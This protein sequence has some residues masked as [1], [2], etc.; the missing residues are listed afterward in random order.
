MKPF[1]PLTLRTQILLLICLVFVILTGL[2]T[3]KAFQ[4]FDKIKADKLN[5]FRL[6]ARW[7]VSEEQRHLMLARHVAFLVINQLR[8]GLTAK[9][10]R[11][12]VVGAPGLDRDFGKFALAATNGDVSCN[13]ISWLTS[14]NVAGQ[15][16]FQKALRGDNLDFIGE[17]DNRDPAKY[18]AIMAHTMR[19]QDGHA[20]KVILVGLDFSWIKEEIEKANLP[21]EVH[22]LMVD[23]KGVVI[24]GSSNMAS[25]VDRSIAD[26]VF[27]KQV[28]ASKETAFEGSGFAGSDS[29]ITVHSFST[30]SGDIRVIIDYPDDAI[31][32]SA[33]RDLATTIL[34][35]VVVLVLILVLAYYWSEKYFL[36][37]ISVIEDAA[38]KLA[39]GD[40]TAR[41]DLA[42]NDELAQLAKNFNMMA[43]AIQVHRAKDSFFA[44]MS[45]E[46][47]T[48]LTGMLGMMEVLSLTPLNREQNDTLRAAWSSGRSLLRIVSD[49]LDWSKIEEEGLALDPSS[50]SIF[51]LV[52]EVANTYSRVA[53][54]K[55]LS[56]FH[57]VDTRLSPA[58]IVD[59]MRL[60]QV[61][62][63][64]VS[65]A[66]KFTPRGEVELRADLLEK[67]ENSE[68]IC[69]SVRDTGIGIAKDVQQH[70][71]Q[72]YRQGSDDTTRLYGGTG[73]GLAICR[74][75]VESM[76]GLIELVSEPERGS[77]FSIIL[78]LPTSAVPL[79]RAPNPHPEVEE[80]AVK[81]LLDGSAEAPLVL[82]VDDHPINRNLLA[83]Q[84]KLL[85]LRAETAE[86][87]QMALSM[88]QKGHY[89]L[90]IT[91]CHM[92]EMDGYSLSRAIRNIE[93]RE[94]LPRTT[95]IAW[96]ANA[97]PEEAGYCYAA[98]M[99]ELLI[100]PTSMMQLKRVL[101]KWLFSPQAGGSQYELPLHDMDNEQNA[102]PIDYAELEKVVPDRAEHTQTL[103]DFE[104]HIRADREKLLEMLAQG[105]TVNVERTAHRMGGSC[106]MVG[107][108][109]LA[110]VCAAIERAGQNGD[111]AGARAEMT[112]LDK[113]LKQLEA[114]LSGMSKR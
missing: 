30:G 72:R 95:I 11:Q 69:F 85:G 2:T 89:A 42:G 25:W 38:L 1:P 88:W 10:C 27:Y 62:N 92:P 112:V 37:K 84:I 48:P 21:A 100:K 8:K 56:L 108:V 57:H 75:V 36:R 101:A 81:P 19:D 31:F 13:S 96:T 5:E 58:H 99:D 110:A 91:D 106:W 65:N 41:A 90:V 64:F 23:D 107:A 16:Y 68:K 86:N 24:A 113:A 109:S 94:R 32:Q 46:I 51:Q 82:A 60:S 76:D 17:A 93:A 102:S 49:I 14:G 73:L 22:L 7:I 111:M 104:L 33:Y 67:R 66:I 9:D 52:Q 74:R 45:H 80:R 26:T 3:L 77:T 28:L 29:A 61:L 54:A 78:T 71:F 50:T 34:S 53:S 97:L 6:T 87:G 105:D 98:D 40:F 12:G 20:L 18:A 59:G 114:H 55:S 15:D 44:T 35:N 47:R 63:N 43:D 4:S 83:L 70:L 39:D 103:H 79:E